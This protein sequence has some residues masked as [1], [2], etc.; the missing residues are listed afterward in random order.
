[1]GST[2]T[3]DR[4][5]GSKPRTQPQ[6]KSPQ[7]D[8]ELKNLKTDLLR[9]RRQY[10]ATAENLRTHQNYMYDQLR[11]LWA[12]IEGLGGGGGGDIPDPT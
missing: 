2:S 7:L 8:R 9:E 3:G 4:A 6:V 1:M 5:R 10:K 12:E 11:E